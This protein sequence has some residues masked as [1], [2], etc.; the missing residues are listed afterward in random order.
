MEGHPQAD[1]V[2]VT[3]G[4]GFIGRWTVAKLTQR[5]HNVWVLARNVVKREQEYHAWIQ[6]H[7]G[8]PKRVRLLE[9][10]LGLPHLGLS[11]EQLRDLEDVAVVYHM[12]AAFQWGLHWR[13]AQRITVGGSEA[14]MAIAGGLPRLK[15]VVHLSGYMIAAEENWSVV[16]MS[17]DEPV[18]RPIEPERLRSLYRR[19]GA[20]EASKIE[21]HFTVQRLSEAA[22]IPLTNILLSSVIG[23]SQSGEIDQP[24]G[25]SMLLD[26]VRT[27][28]LA[29]IPGTPRDWMPLITVDFLVDFIVG[30]L[31]LENTCNQ[32]Y[33]L[34]DQA[35]PNFATFVKW[36]SED[37]GLKPPRY[38]IPK[39]WLQKALALGLDR[40]MGISAETLDFLQPYSFD[41]A[42]ADAV[43]RQLGLTKPDIRQA[44]ASMVAYLQSEH[45]YQQ[46]QSIRGT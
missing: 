5:G 1:T 8:E 13:E 37:L 11:L 19:L 12:G 14:L 9:S 44:V 46:E 21:A 45:G 28:K 33:V 27:G 3:G 2:L 16:G 38:H 25:V 20:Y 10:D 26:Q 15:R 4:T 35:T 17:P 41:T 36:L 6:R 22:G 31:C 43:A 24:H 40:V 29:M 32:N 18:H 34:L 30:I 42:S 23:H 7:G 39:W